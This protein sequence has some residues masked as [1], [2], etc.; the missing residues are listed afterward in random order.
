MTLLICGLNQYLDE[1]VALFTPLFSIQAKWCIQENTYDVRGKLLG[2]YP[3]PTPSR[4]TF[5]V[6]PSAAAA[7]EAMNKKLVLPDPVLIAI[8]AAC[9][10]V[11]NLSGT[12]EQ[13]DQILRDLENITVLADDGSMAE[14][15]SSRLSTSTSRFVDVRG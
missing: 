13:A 14:L 6:E 1:Y 3:V 12:A 2:W 15:L 8:R 4:V 7:A 11:A 9:A 5:S 10:R